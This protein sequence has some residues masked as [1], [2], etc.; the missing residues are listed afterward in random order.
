L[1][2][3]NIVLPDNFYE[4]LQKIKKKYHLR[5]NAEAICKALELVEE[6]INA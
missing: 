1:I 5:N 4:I 3:V 2:N 6:I